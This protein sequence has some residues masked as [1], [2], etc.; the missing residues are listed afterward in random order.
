MGQFSESGW[1]KSSALA[2]WVCECWETYWHPDAYEASE[3]E[4]GEESFGSE[5]ECQQRCDVLNGLWV[6]DNR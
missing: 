3:V 5:L 1:S 4:V 2:I 6:D